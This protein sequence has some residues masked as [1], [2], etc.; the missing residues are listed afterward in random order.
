MKRFFFFAFLVF[1]LMFFYGCGGGGNSGSD[2]SPPE[3]PA[4]L[5]KETPRSET[6]ETNRSNRRNRENS[7]AKSRKREPSGREWKNATGEVIDR[8]DLVSMMDGNV[9]I[10]TV[11]GARM[12][13]LADLCEED[14]AFVK[15]NTIDVAQIEGER[16]QP[17]EFSGDVL[18]PE[19]NP[20]L[21]ATN[22]II[23]D[24]TD[25]RD[26]S[27]LFVGQKVFVPFDLESNF[28]K[29]RY[30]GMVGTMLY[31]KLDRE[32][33]FIIPEAMQD[34]RST[35]EMISFHPT[36]DT[37]LA[38]VQKVLK[39]SF[40]GNI[41]SWGKIERVPPHDFEIYDFTLIC[42]D[43][44]ENPPKIIHGLRPLSEK[45]DVPKT[46]KIEGIENEIEVDVIDTKQIPG[47]DYVY[48]VFRTR[49]I[50]EVDGIHV[51]NLMA[52]LYERKPGE[53]VIDPVCEENWEKNPNLVVGGDFE[54][55]VNGIP[56]GW[57][58][59]CAQHREPVGRLV[60]WVRD[61]DDPSN[62][63][64]NLTF[65]AEIGDGFGLMYYS[66]PFIVEEGALYRF[67]CRFKSNGPH[68]KIFIK[69][70]DVLDSRFNPTPQ[71]L[72]EGYA[73]SFGQ[74]TREVYRSQ[75]NLEGPLNTW[76]TKTEDFTPR[77]TKYSPK[78]GRVMLYGYL[79][80]GTIEFDDIV[81]KQIRPAS[82]SAKKGALRHSLD[83]N[84]T[85]EEMR[86]NERR[87]QEAKEKQ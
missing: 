32:K 67:Q 65:D 81:I 74:Q 36:P 40:N 56:V 75:Q 62:H 83:T 44:T 30:G 10:M 51:E 35:C 68:P 17:L 4:Q 48:D 71:G 14:Q 24:T 3:Q 15:A 27:Q 72:Q 8:G 49:A 9:G 2:T 6:G 77:H 29:G 16:E 58:T 54:K 19:N 28:D 84:V 70:S 47:S 26:E 1:S 20:D 73:D 66:K 38:E 87:A 55:A 52:S 78:F 80:A 63:V 41:A 79:G 21:A 7:S 85:L 31:K 5:A 13:P 18:V 69:C 76:N 34:I 23:I 53:K 22:E 37:P 39:Q 61:S 43:F 64:I 50:G 46:F 57:E 12:I 82:P 42:V 45:N 25:P 86:D 59:K 11:D 60:R 33:G